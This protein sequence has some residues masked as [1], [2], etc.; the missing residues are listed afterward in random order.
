MR[1]FRILI[2]LW[3]AVSASH[4]IP[5]SE[6]PFPKGASAADL[7]SFLQAH[8]A[9][10][11]NACI[12]SAFGNLNELLPKASL[13]DAEVSVIIRFLEYRR[14]PRED[15]MHGYRI[16]SNTLGDQYPAITSL[17]LIGP[18]ASGQLISTLGKPN[19]QRFQENAE[20]AWS[21][22]YR[23]NPVDGVRVLAHAALLEHD[24]ERS[25]ELRNATAAVAEN[26]PQNVWHE[27]ASELPH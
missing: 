6:C 20:F 7:V 19:T 11:T 13:N 15:E 16:H 22:I 17:F 21:Q 27:C 2:C 12:G 10:E 1:V 26:C 24:P 3:A 18:K 23:D 25:K 8:G 5:A 14:S 4:Q 9:K